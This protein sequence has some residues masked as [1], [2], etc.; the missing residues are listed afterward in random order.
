MEGTAKREIELTDRDRFWLGHLKQ[1]ASEKI[2][3][4][5]YAARNKLSVQ[6]L[7][8]G[9]KRLVSLGAWPRAER[10]PVFDRIRIVKH[11]LPAAPASVARPEAA[12]R[13]RLAPGMVIEW[14]TV[15]A[16]EWLAQLTRQLGSSR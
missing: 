6:A 11:P 12:M 2:D 4:K 15:P 1:I 8:Q 13:L 14:P 9:K 5:A 16:P 7:Y 10:R 3:A